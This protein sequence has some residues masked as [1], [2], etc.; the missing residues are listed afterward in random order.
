MKTQKLFIITL[1]LVLT[2]LF[3][4]TTNAQDID[5]NIGGMLAY[6][7]EIENIGIGANAEFGIADKISI[8]PSFIYYL[9]KEEGPVKVTWFEFNA[10]V[11]Y[12]FIQDEQFDVYGLGGLNY[13]NV[14]VKFDTNAFG[15][16]GGN[17][18]G[19]DGRIG[20]NLGG[21]ANLKLNGNITPFAELKYVIIDGGQLV[22]AAGVRFNL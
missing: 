13:T 9:P 21:G 7:T 5:T 6:G 12:Y 17:A 16:F 14:N 1:S 3:S 4:N 18:S 19:S 11:N 8:S 20:L 2:C 10:N 22:L 15:G